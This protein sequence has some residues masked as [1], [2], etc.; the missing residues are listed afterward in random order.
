MVNNQGR[1]NNNVAG[2]GIYTTN[3]LKICSVNVNSH[4]SIKR[5]ISLNNFI[6]KEKADIFTLSETRLNNKHNLNFQNYNLIRTDR[7]NNSDG[8]TAI[9]IKNNISYEIVYNKNADSCETIE[10][11]IVKIKCGNNK[12]IY[13]I[14]CYAA[15]NKSD[16]NFIK[17]LDTLMKEF[18]I[19]KLNNYIM[20]IGDMNAKHPRW[21]NQHTDNRGTKLNHWYDQNNLSC[22]CSLYA[23]YKPSYPRTNSFLDMCII[24]SRL[25]LRKAFN[26]NINCLKN[27][28][29]SSDH[30]AME[31]DIDI[32]NS[33]NSFDILSKDNI[34]Q[35]DYQN[36][37]WNKLVQCFEKFYSEFSQYNNN[38][39]IN[40]NRN[41][42]HVPHDRNLTNDEIDEFILNFNQMITYVIEK[43]VPKRRKWD[44]FK[45]FETPLIKNL[46]RQKSQLVTRLKNGNRTFSLSM[47]ETNTLKGLIKNI[48]VLIDSNLKN[49]ISNYW[50]GK[51]T[52]IS[53]RNA[54][55]EIKK[56]FRDKNQII[57][58]CLEV[59]NNYREVLDDAEIN[60]AELAVDENDKY[61]VKNPEQKVNLLASYFVSHSSKEP[62]SPIKHLV[63]DE[64]SNL[65]R[66]MQNLP[67]ITCFSSNSLSSNPHDT[68]EFISS[69]E[70][71]SIF[72]NLNTKRSF[73]IDKIPNII[74]RKLPK[75][76]IK[77]YTILFNNMINNSHFPEFWKVAKVVP[78]LKPLKEQ[79]D[80]ASY[81][82]ISL[83]TNIS[84]VFEIIIHNK[85]L[86][87][88][89]ENKCIP[90]NQYGF[91]KQHSTY[92]AMAK[93]YSDICWAKNG[94]NA[95]GALLIDYKS[96]F[97]TIWL[98]GLF[99]KL[100]QIC[101]PINLIKMI[102]S[103]L[104]N[105]KLFV[106]LREND[107]E[108][109]S[110]CFILN[111]GLQQGT[112]CAPTM[113][114][115]YTA[116]SLKN[117]NHSLA[118]ADDVICYHADKRVDLIN[119]ELCKKLNQAILYSKVWGLNINFAKCESIL[120]RHPVNLCNNDIRHNWKNF[121][122]KNN[123]ITIQNKDKVRYL[124]QLCDKFTYFHDHIKTQ[125]N[126]CQGRVKS[127]GKLFYS[128][129]IRKDVK[130]LAYQSLIRPLLIYGCPIWFNL[131]HTYMEK[132]RL[133]ERRILRICLKM[134]REEK[135]D[136]S[137]K[138][139]SNKRVYNAANISRIDCFILKICRNYHARAITIDN[140]TIRGYYY[141]N[142]MYFA[143]TSETGCIPPEAFTFLDSNNMLQN[144]SNVPI[145][146]HLHRRATN[147]SINYD[148]STLTYSQSLPSKDENDRSRINGKLNGYYWWL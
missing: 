48:N 71:E 25:V 7:L 38:I 80:I 79:K 39:E 130:I 146:Y 51:L 59:T 77:Q 15:P 65:K 27:V 37:D 73:G 103:M 64:I 5:R 92:H 124:G 90:A 137:I 129:H 133:M 10:N 74:L 8:G 107:I 145:I 81:R 42:I 23:T 119:Y 30:T 121:R 52:K 143:R 12:N 66:E 113:F 32:S 85:I 44:G 41:K 114:S 63:N 75:I 126:K 69:E 142:P 144:A 84:K 108:Y 102:W 72:R 122:V 13:V 115:V 147:K 136:G 49:T 105:K 117:E 26:N 47:Q 6:Q 140:E 99:Y 34:I 17:D 50:R 35:Y 104:R 96:A 123:D 16:E 116:D 86:K 111:N 128:N 46:Y 14:S 112:I 68:N 100:R 56:M 135:S 33:L 62:D 58:P 82:P 70:V 109:K 9:L 93:L 127:L 57:T 19:N 98:D 89:E 2:V 76:I 28:E 60:V 53:K 36:T 95:V 106:E 78:S 29:Y 4:I 45:M 67:Q 61:L 97:D 148:N 132:L 125:L 87:F 83:L 3:F 141:P 91:K 22:R 21:K 43:I 54:F 134:H 138:Y 88:C 24:D 110:K 120:F 31:L 40:F 11:T 101:F 18:Q 139:I 118:F 94:N 1:C 131:N 55:P 20:L